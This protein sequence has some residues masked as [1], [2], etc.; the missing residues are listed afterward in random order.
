MPVTVCSF[1][2]VTN[3][4]GKFIVLRDPDNDDNGIVVLS[5]FMRDFQHRDILSRWR[6]ANKTTPEKSGLRVAGGGWWK[7]ENALLVLYG[8][9][10]AYGR[11]DPQ[12]LRQHIQP[13]S[14][15]TESAIDV[16]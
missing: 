4:G 13:G 15:L 10:A 14:V 2:K 9:S 1:I 7:L 16:R 8:Q 3:S 11:F 5:D 6:E 12:W